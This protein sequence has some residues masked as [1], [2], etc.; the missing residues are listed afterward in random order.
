LTVGN[1]NIYDANAGDVRREQTRVVGSVVFGITALNAG[2]S[3]SGDNRDAVVTLLAKNDAIIS[4][5]FQL[6]EW[7]LIVRAFC[8]LNAEDVRLVFVE[9]GDDRVQPYTDGVDVIRGN[10]HH[11]LKD[12]STVNAS[13]E[14]KMAENSSSS[15]ASVAIVVIILLAT[16]AFYLLF[17]RSV[18]AKRDINIEIRGPAHEMPIDKR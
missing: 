14:A 15:V 10:F 16:F 7:K 8:F 12:F 11:K 5:R 17:G 9:P 13:R 4:D 18:H 3:R 6:K 2:A 1:I